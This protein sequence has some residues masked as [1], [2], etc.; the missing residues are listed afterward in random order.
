MTI[1]TTFFRNSDAA[2]KVA[3]SNFVTKSGAYEG[4]IAQAS[5]R[6]SPGGATG[7][8]IVFKTTDG[9]NA[10][11]TLWIIAKDGSRTFQNDIFDAILAVLGLESVEAKAGNVFGRK[12]EKAQGYRLFDIENKPLGLVIQRAQRFY[13][14]QQTGEER[15]TYTLNILT[16]F[17]PATRKVAKEILDGEEA[18]R[19]DGIVATL[20]DKPGKHVAGTSAA[21]TEADVPPKSDVHDDDIP[22]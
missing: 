17:D 20:K 13:V 12:G 8:D 3:S 7:L 6:E 14:D 5:L 22:F 21:Y 15:E 9:A 11:L 4:R 16:P 10:F 18:K 1:P 2:K 19:L